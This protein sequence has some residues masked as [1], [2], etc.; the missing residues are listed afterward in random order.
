MSETN[1]NAANKN[2]SPEAHQAGET[3]TERIFKEAVDQIAVFRANT[4]AENTPTS[5]RLIDTQQL[6]GEGVP[7][8]PAALEAL[9]GDY[10]GPDAVRVHSGESEWMEELLPFSA[11]DQ[12]IAVADRYML[13]G[14]MEVRVDSMREP[15]TSPVW[16]VISVSRS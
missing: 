13:P 14:G 10:F 5:K 15:D 12:K 8:E 2:T 7:V 4:V 6:A 3:P 9:I 16:T 1:S 11:S